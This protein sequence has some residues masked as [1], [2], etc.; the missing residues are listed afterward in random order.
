M[1]KEDKDRGVT[2]AV[3]AHGSIFGN[4]NLGNHLS[5]ICLPGSLVLEL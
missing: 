4:R 1:D 2:V 3:P 5:D